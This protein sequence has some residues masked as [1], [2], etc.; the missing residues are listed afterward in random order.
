MA[1]A[2]ARHNRSSAPGRDK[3]L[4]LVVRRGTIVK[5]GCLIG[6]RQG[7]LFLDY[8][9]PGGGTGGPVVD[10]QGD[11]VG[12]VMAC[13]DYIAI[14]LPISIV[15][16]CFRMWTD[17]RFVSHLVSVYFYLYH[18][19]IVSLCG[20]SL[21]LFP[22]FPGRFSLGFPVLTLKTFIR[23][24]GII[25]LSVCFLVTELINSQFFISREHNSCSNAYRLRT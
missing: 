18:L 1:S 6:L 4:S 15:L 7:Y 23:V 12:M 11:V 21:G 13:D 3:D 16:S 14:I 19:L 10:H 2:I 9:L 20:L 25:S 5:D 22:I 8:E 24:I 17:F